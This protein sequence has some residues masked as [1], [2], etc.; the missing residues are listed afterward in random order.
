MNIS[1]IVFP[2]TNRE[3]DMGMAFSSLTG[4][5]PNF[6]W[7]KDTDLPQSDLIVLPGGFSYGDYLRCGAMAAHSPIMKEV[8]HKAK[9]GTRVLGVCNGFQMLIETQLLPGALLRNK[10]LKFICK[11]VSLRTEN[12]DTSFAHHLNDGDVIRVPVAHGDGNYFANEDILKSLEDH[13]QIAFRY[14][15]TNGNVTGEANP[16]GSTQN[17]A[18]IYNKEKTILG[19]MPHPENATQIHQGPLEGKPLF[20]SILNQAA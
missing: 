20:E 13:R 9:S 14:C 16:N 11:Q 15:D 5:Q 4:Q 18:G 1:I 7:H 17:I 8:I 19:M 2:G 12:T 3:K 6:V 10:T